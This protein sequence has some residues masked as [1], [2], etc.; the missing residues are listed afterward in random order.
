MPFIFGDLGGTQ[1]G[2]RGVS[3]TEAMQ[4]AGQAWESQTGRLWPV[5]TGELS[6]VL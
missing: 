2:F 4:A 5:G 3:D 1:L 6:K